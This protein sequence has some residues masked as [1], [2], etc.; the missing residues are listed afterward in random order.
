[1]ASL[2]EF[3]RGPA[4]DVMREEL[5][6]RDEEISRLRQYI[7]DRFAAQDRRNAAQD[8]HNEETDVRMNA[9]SK[10]KTQE[11]GLPS[12]Q[13]LNHQDIKTKLNN[14][15]DQVL[16][17]IAISTADSGAPRQEAEVI[18][19]LARLLFPAE[20]S[21][22]DA[23]ILA[24]Q[25]TEFGVQVPPDRLHR[26]CAL[27]HE[28]RTA[29]DATGHAIVWDFTLDAGRPL[30]PERQQPHGSCGAQ[31]AADFVTVPGYSADGKVYVK[32]RVFTRPHPDRTPQQEPAGV[33]PP[34]QPTTGEPAELTVR[35]LIPAP[36]TVVRALLGSLQ[37]LARTIRTA[38]PDRRV[39]L[40]AETPQG[41]AKL[42]VLEVG[43]RP[44]CTISP[45]V[46]SDEVKVKIQGESDDVIRFARWLQ[47]ELGRHD[48][49]IYFK[50]ADPRPWVQWWILPTH[51]DQ[52][53]REVL[54]GPENESRQ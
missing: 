35:V 44:V 19:R 52:H 30:D 4:W 29:A 36:G 45:V 34:E 20:G 41:A 10:A 16:L 50:R 28:I 14:L 26:A 22:P 43:D 53:F 38:R 7:D 37:E 21:S 17:D 13:H 32:Q 46:S 25:L 40:A 11:R 12:A 33:L 1:M 48:L 31:D 42:I 5:I 2:R 18:G 3:V 15:A 6:K 54:L 51:D 27:S 23:D 39:K 24:Q 49:E 9:L 47:A 8:R